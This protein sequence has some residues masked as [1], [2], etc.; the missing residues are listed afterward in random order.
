MLKPRV[1]LRR[2]V[3]KE[4]LSSYRDNYPLFTC[5]MLMVGLRQLGYHNG[6]IREFQSLYIN[7]LK[8]KYGTNFSDTV[9]RQE[10]PPKERLQNL[11]D[12]IKS[13]GL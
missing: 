4:F 11:L 5:N 2:L 6:D 1:T 9:F 3:I 10:P 8:L 7:S 13:E 12:F